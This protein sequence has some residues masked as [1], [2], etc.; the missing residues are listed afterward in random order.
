M[1]TAFA[2]GGLGLAVLVFLMQVL[3]W[4]L[5]PI[6]DVATSGPNSDAES[7]VRVG[8]YFSALTLENLVLIAAIA[9]AIALIGRAV[10]ERRVGP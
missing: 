2:K 3:R 8:S 6:L 7:V 10:V 4:I 5:T 9:V 1:W